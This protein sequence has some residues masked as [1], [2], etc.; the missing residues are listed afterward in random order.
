MSASLCRRCF[1][2]LKDGDKVSV[3]VT[4]TYHTLKSEVAYALDKADMVAD[5]ETLVHASYE[6]CD[7]F[8]EEDYGNDDPDNE[9]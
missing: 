6:G 2:L 1:G 7:S 5:P 9:D 3:V 4:S 8:I